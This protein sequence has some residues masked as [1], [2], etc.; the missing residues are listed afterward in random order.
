MFS[1]DPPRDYVSGTKPN[2]MRIE[3]E[4]ERERERTRIDRVLGSH[5]L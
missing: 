2:Q 5:L 3:R 1:M 4:R